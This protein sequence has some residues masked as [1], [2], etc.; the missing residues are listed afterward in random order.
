[1]SSPHHQVPVF[2]THPVH[3]GSRFTVYAMVT[4]LAAAFN[5]LVLV[6]LGFG[7]MPRIEEGAVQVR[8]VHEDVHALKAE[9]DGARREMREYNSVL[10]WWRDWLKAAEARKKKGKK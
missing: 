5:L 2:T 6:F 4:G 1:M 3:N 9:L 10:T 7:I 8:A